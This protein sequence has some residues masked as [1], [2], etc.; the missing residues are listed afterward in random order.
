MKSVRLTV[1]LSELK[2]GKQLTNVPIQVRGSEADQWVVSPASAAVIIEGT[3]SR[4]EEVTPESVGLSLYVD[5]SNIFITPAD[6]ALRAEV[7]S[8]DF[9]VVKI[10]PSTV[11][12]NAAENPKR[13]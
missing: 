11:T 6:L 13:W 9:R 7:A 3:P 4:V 10:E 5:L 12:V 1:T 2:A 8:A